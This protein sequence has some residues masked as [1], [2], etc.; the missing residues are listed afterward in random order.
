MVLGVYPKPVLD[1]I[2]PSVNRLVAQVELVT[3]THQPPV[4]R[5]RHP[6]GRRPARREAA[7]GGGP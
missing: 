6:A 2:T 4:A 7:T 5:Y 1:R 3:H